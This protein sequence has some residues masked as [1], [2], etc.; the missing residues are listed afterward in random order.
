MVYFSKKIEVDQEQY[1]IWIAPPIGLHISPAPSMSQN[2]DFGPSYKQ[3]FPFA[4]F[5]IGKR[6]KI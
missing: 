6:A 3:R 2:H 5:S 4:E 1:R